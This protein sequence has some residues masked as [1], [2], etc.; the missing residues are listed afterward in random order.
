V[1]SAFATTE[2][3]YL[4]AKNSG[5]RVCESHTG[6]GHYAS[7]TRVE[8]GCEARGRRACV[9]ACVCVTKII[10]HVTIDRR[11]LPN[12]YRYEE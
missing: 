10:S 3:E 6:V 4:D 7:D 2:K 9:P 1:K 5:T 8:N 12:V 11:G